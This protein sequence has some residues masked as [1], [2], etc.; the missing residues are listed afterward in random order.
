MDWLLDLLFGPPPL[1]EDE[2]NAEIK[3]LI[4]SDPE[5]SELYA[6]TKVDP[7]VCECGDG[8]RALYHINHREIWINPS[9]LTRDAL[10]EALLHEYIHASDHIV[11]GIDIS[12]ILGLATTEVHAMAQCECRN[13]WFPR[14]CVF[15]N[16]VQAVTLAT[17]DKEK[18]EKAVESV[19]EDAYET[20]DPDPTPSWY[21][22]TVGPN[23]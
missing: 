17:H 18:A 15:Q 8:I 6:A 9:G 21:Y 2:L 3:T 14:S 20:P 23:E 11:K 10:R 4:S 19:F 1:S 5:I 12:T 16:A 22:Y 7:R 13:A